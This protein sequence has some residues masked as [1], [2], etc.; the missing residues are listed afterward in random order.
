MI[1]FIAIS[2]YPSPVV[3]LEFCISSTH[4][5]T[6]IHVSST[7]VYCYTIDLCELSTCRPCDQKLISKASRVLKD[8]EGA[9][10]SG[11]IVFSTGCYD[12][13]TMDIDDDDDDDGMLYCSFPAPSLVL[14]SPPPHLIFPSLPPPSYCHPRPLP[15]IAIPAPSS[16][17]LIP[18]PSL[19]LPSP[20]PPSY[21]HPRPLTSYSHPHP[22]TLTTQSFT[23]NIWFI[24]S[25]QFPH[26]HHR[27][28]LLHQQ[29]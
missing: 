7:T 2:V 17:I 1:H 23:A 16:H 25:C 10:T 26:Q 19:V 14:P 24:Y 4:C 28:H 21:C 12:D 11:V 6:G 29:D 27:M 20:P 9:L 3:T 13:S 15:R 22:L 8:L 5:D 18:A